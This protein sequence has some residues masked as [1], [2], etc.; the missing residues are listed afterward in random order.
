MNWAVADFETSVYDGQTETEAWACGFMEYGGKPEIYNNIGSFMKR[1]SYTEYNTIIFF[2]NLKFD[3]SFI[4]PYLL[5][6][7][8]KIACKNNEMRSGKDLKK[9]EFNC[10]IN[11]KGIWYRIE[12]RFPNGNLISIYDSLKLIPFSLRDAGNAFNTKHRKL[13]MEYKGK[14]EA[15]QYI[16]PNEKKY[17]EHDLYVLYECMEIIFSRDIKKSTI[18]SQCLY[19][20]RKKYGYFEY[21]VDFPNLY[22]LETET[23]FKSVGDYILRSYCGAYI[24]IKEGME[25]K[26]ITNGITIDATSLYPSVMHSKSGFIYPYGI[27]KYGKGR[28]IKKPNRYYYQRIKCRFKVKSGYLPF[29]R[30]RGNA[31][32]SPRKIQKASAY[33]IKGYIIDNSVELIL[34]MN[35]LELF[36]EHY[37]L[38]D[39]EYID[40]YEFYA[41]A[42]MFDDYVNE[43]IEKKE[44]AKNKVE[45]TI[46][47]LY[48]NNL[49]GKFSAVPDS[50]FHVPFLD[51]DGVVNF[52]AVHE[53]K[54]IP[55]YIA[56]GSAIISHARITDVRAC[57]AN[58]DNFVYTDTDSLHLSCGIDAVRGVVIDKHKLCTFKHE[59]S[60]DIAIFNNVK[61]YIEH[62]I[63][64][65][66]EPCT[67]KYSI[68][69]AGMIKK[70]KALLAL[71]LEDKL[72]EETF[73]KYD[74]DIDKLSEND[75]NFILQNKK[76]QDF[77]S[78]LIVPAG[79]LKAKRIKGGTILYEGDF[80]IL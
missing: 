63:E 30:I 2:H 79:K 47:K 3:G 18:G 14:R 24:Y 45:R 26:V 65:D 43:W 38:Y 22:E 12:I 75:L 27:P 72:D 56:V 20:F 58:Y 54:A 77:T 31:E 40:Y 11:R 44:G 6:S 69:C 15:G 52:T 17:L 4:I 80:T 34:N 13:E 9:K 55:G 49:Y 41:R 68:T 19:Y 74:Y 67:P 59:S 60:W 48:L 78:G 7:G 62:I 70:G 57:Q 71:A 46:A 51:E 37:N 33:E 21:K 16:N 66:G 32:Y 10:H 8:Y 36:K 76:I 28:F 50:S 42:G 29:I 39:L 1:I 35:E 25:D 53:E 64:E 5:N 23:N 73:K 61:R